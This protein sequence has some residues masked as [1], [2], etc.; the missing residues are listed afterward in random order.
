MHNSHSFV[1]S[2]QVLQY[3][4]FDDTAARL[5]MKARTE[6][7]IYKICIDLANRRKTL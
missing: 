7:C 5:V 1:Q 2:L 4:T 6:N 3:I